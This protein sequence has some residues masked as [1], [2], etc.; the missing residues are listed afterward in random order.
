MF[1]LSVTDL[2]RGMSKKQIEQ[3]GAYTQFGRDR[4]EQQGSGLGLSIAV[5]IVD[6]H[7]GDFSIISELDNYTTVVIKLPVATNFEM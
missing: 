1:I 4:Y 3:I 5:K 6:L 2:G 7:N